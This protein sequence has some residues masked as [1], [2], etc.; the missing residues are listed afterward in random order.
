MPCVGFEP[1]IPASERA[2]TV[3]ALDRAATAISS[4]SVYHLHIIPPFDVTYCVCKC[5][6]TINVQ[7]AGSPRIAFLELLVYVVFLS[8]LFLS[9]LRLDALFYLLLLSYCVAPP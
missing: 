2:K 8:Y 6:H 5:T 9:L 4:F 1:M 7:V 3:H